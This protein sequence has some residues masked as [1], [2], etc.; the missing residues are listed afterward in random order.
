MT[1]QATTNH[2]DRETTV[3]TRKAPE[4][5]ASQTDADLELLVNDQELADS[6]VAALSAAAGIGPVSA[7][8]LRPV[9]KGFRAFVEQESYEV[10]EIAIVTLLQAV[11]FGKDV[12][13]LPLTALGRHQHQTLIS[14]RPLTVA[15][16]PGCRG[17]VRAWSQ[18]TGVWV[19]GVL[20]EQYGLDL[21]SIQWRTYSRGHVPE[22][23][24]PAWVTHAEDGSALAEDLLEGR[25]DFAVMGNDRPADPRVRNIVPDPADAAAEWS[26]EVGFVPVNHVIAVRGATARAHPDAVLAMYDTLAATLRTR[27]ESDDGLPVNPVGFEALR[28]AV[29]AAARFA[30]AQGLLPRELGYDELVSRTCAA[31]G[32]DPSRLGA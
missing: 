18:T 26:A 7:S 30:H 29:T 24:E 1:T 17:G 23:P 2:P 16:L 10:S 22:Q 4:M 14:T 20:A 31:L 15:D 3:T 6:A 28:P 19:R 8:P 12:H 13:L 27:D 11:A 9:H 21:S 25:V 32:V 5:T